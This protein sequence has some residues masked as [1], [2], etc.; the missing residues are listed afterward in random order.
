MYFTV[1]NAVC[2]M[3]SATNQKPTYQFNDGL[4]LN[5]RTSSSTNFKLILTASI[6]YLATV[7]FSVVDIS[8][9]DDGLDDND[10]E[11]SLAGADL[12]GMN[13]PARDKEIF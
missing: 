1:L 5:S 3:Q 10:N 2:V 9:D 4:E 11:R 13:P 6:L 12:G 7:H 8:Y